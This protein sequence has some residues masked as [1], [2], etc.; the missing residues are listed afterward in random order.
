MIARSVLL[1]LIAVGTALAC[2]P[3]GT[4]L[5]GFCPIDANDPLV[6]EM[7]QF[8]VST[9]ASRTN[10]VNDGSISVDHAWS[11]VR[12]FSHELLIVLKQKSILDYFKDIKKYT[13]F[14]SCFNLFSIRLC[15]GLITRWQSRLDSTDRYCVHRFE[16]SFSNST[17]R[18][19]VHISSLSVFHS[20]LNIICIFYFDV[21]P[22][23]VTLW[24]M[25]S[26]G[27]VHVSSPMTNVTWSIISATQYEKDM[28]CCWRHFT[29]KWNVVICT[30]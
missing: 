5:G 2:G 22:M 9:H 14:L 13:T 1:V 8:A 11:Q 4:T 30:L 20:Y 27:Q 23:N 24:S 6:Q 10:A 21:R 25:T 18:Y 29:I 3:P 19:S 17:A 16:R 12:N 15:L 7:A 28:V 26:L